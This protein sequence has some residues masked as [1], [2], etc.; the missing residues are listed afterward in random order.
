M[1]MLICILVILFLCCSAAAKDNIRPDRLPQ[2]VKKVIATA[3]P[4]SRIHQAEIFDDKS[5]Y[6][7]E[8]AHDGHK[9]DVDIR[10]DGS[11]IKAEREIRIADV[12][13]PVTAA[14]QA[15]HPDAKI[16][17]AEEV[18]VGGV[19][20]FEIDF[21]TGG[22]KRRLSLRLDGT[23]APTAVTN[24]S[25]NPTVRSPEP[26]RFRDPRPESKAGPVSLGDLV[27]YAMPD[28]E[29]DI[30]IGPDKIEWFPGKNSIIVAG[31]AKR[32]LSEPGDKVEIKLRWKCEGMPDFV[33]HRD[34]PD[35]FV[36]VEETETRFGHEMKFKRLVLKQ[37]TGSPPGRR[38]LFTE[39]RKKVNKTKTEN[40]IHNW[41][42][43]GALRIGLFGSGAPEYVASISGS[44]PPREARRK[45]IGMLADRA[46]GDKR[47]TLRGW[48]IHVSPHL[49]ID[50]RAEGGRT[51]GMFARRKPNRPLPTLLLTGH[52]LLEFEPLQ[53]F[54]GFG[55]PLDKE[56]PF[57]ITAE[58]LADSKVKLTVRFG[59]TIYSHTDPDAADQSQWLDTLVLFY[60][61]SIP[62]YGRVTIRWRREARR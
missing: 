26:L 23:P 41:S 46:G 48:S 31:F 30:G 2:V 7:L 47:G 62:E 9:I 19:T 51:P 59:E 33:P 56:V 27:I 4:G 1:R 16:E 54:G 11:I 25:D 28:G 60:P 21:E 24:I 44:M 57:E 20:V 55:V 6:E 32:R 35:Q 12:P 45:W 13:D 22:K 8:V 52:D 34:A 14:I 5:G 3:Y 36:E 40:W 18:T 39:G 29:P 37:A 42:G 38:K 61:S 17:E 58:R 53:K 10:D 50:A 43:D 15:A 49:P